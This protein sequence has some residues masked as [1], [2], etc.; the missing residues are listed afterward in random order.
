MQLNAVGGELL[1][2]SCS[3]RVPNQRALPVADETPDLRSTGPLRCGIIR[4]A[5]PAGTRS[6]ERMGKFGECCGDPQLRPGVDSDPVVAAT[7]IL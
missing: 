2:P 5:E 3:H 7:Q 4:H 1:L 6:S